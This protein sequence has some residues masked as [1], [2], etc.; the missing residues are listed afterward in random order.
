MDREMQFRIEQEIS[1]ENAKRGVRDVK[2]AEMVHE[3]VVFAENDRGRKAESLDRTEEEFLL[4]D[5]KRKAE[6]RAYRELY[7][8]RKLVGGIIV[9]V[10]R[11]I[12]KVLKWYIEPVCNQQTEFNHM[13]VKAV[14]E[15]FESQ[16][17]CKLECIDIRKNV[18]SCMRELQQMTDGRAEE[19]ERKLTLQNEQLKLIAHDL[20]DQKSGILDYFNC[21]DEANEIIDMQGRQIYEAKALVDKLSQSV[22]SVW[23]E[24]EEQRQQLAALD[25]KYDEQYPQYTFGEIMSSSQSGEDTI[26][27]YILDSLKIPFG[28]CTYLDLGANH[29]IA[30]SN[31][32][33]MYRH[34][35]RGVLVEANPNLVPELERIRRGDVVL[36]RCVS[37]R[38]G[39]EK[40][41]Y[42]MNGDGLSTLDYAYA[43]EVMRENT[44]LKV[45]QVVQ[46]QT[47]TVPDIL[48]LYF[49]EPPI[50]VSVDVEGSELQIL[51]GLNL[52]ENRPVVVIVE[53]I[54]Y[55]STLKVGKKK[56][57]IVEYM[58]TLGYAEYAFTGI[59]SIFVDTK[60]I[61][62]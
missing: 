39:E 15:I 13:T 8:C 22:D 27:A 21:V 24:I 59:N 10:K 46:V 31:T 41:F 34:G 50:L 20:S 16:A 9:F 62:D 14:E 3:S 26:V 12:R 23:R 55:S 28:K 4:L 19:F 1:Q 35:A 52:K 37:D 7:S 45:D 18:E 29:P 54:P 61:S 58:A 2:A 51:E 47:I 42:I 38:S 5:M 17:I 48:K 43:Q 11:V 56:S 49:K 33:M 57:E 32:Y 40:D 30:M 53:T 44:S 60:R 36:N 25:I 6:N